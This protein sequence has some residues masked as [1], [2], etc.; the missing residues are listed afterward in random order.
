MRNKQLE[1]TQDSRTAVVPLEDIA[2][3]IC[4]RPDIR[5]STMALTRLAEAKVL[6]VT[7]DSHFLPAATVSPVE[8]NSRHSETIH[9][10]IDLAP[11]LREHPVA[12]HCPAENLYSRLSYGY[13]LLR[14]AIARSLVASGFHPALGLHH[15]NV[16]NS[17]NLA[18]DLIEPFRALAD[19][20][21]K[22]NL[23][24]NTTLSKSVRMAM[25]HVMH[26]TVRISEEIHTVLNAIDMTV[27]SLKRIVTASSSESL[28]LPTI[29][30]VDPSTKEVP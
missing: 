24:T 25:A 7:L 10:Q 28:L 18:D 23:G 5:I 19:I 16:F 27:A 15:R 2:C 20:I 4:I 11:S 9:K 30:P 8:A 17:W 3:I 12:A 1:I 22:Q 21:A 13:S 14:T 26:T 29:I 6:L